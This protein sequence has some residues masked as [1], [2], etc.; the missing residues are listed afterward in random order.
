MIAAPL[1]EQGLRGKMLEADP[2]PKTKPLQ[3]SLPAGLRVR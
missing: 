2:T 3:V 1:V